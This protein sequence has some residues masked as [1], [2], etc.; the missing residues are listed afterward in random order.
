MSFWGQTEDRNRIIHLHDD[1]SLWT[2]SYELATPTS[3]KKPFSHRPFPAN[4]YLHPLASQ[5]VT[6]LSRCC[7]TP[8]PMHQPSAN[9]TTPDCVWGVELLRSSIMSQ[10]KMLGSGLLA[11]SSMDRFPDLPHRRRR[12]S[13]GAT[14][15]PARNQVISLGFKEAAGC[16]WLPVCWLFSWFGVVL[17]LMLE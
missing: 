11:L 17:L 13:A 4:C 10:T 8:L 15:T 3:S 16:S 1:M 9:A 14:H 2:S 6:T 12:L 5:N 7:A